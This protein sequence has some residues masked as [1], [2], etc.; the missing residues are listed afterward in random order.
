MMGNAGR[1]PIFW[2]TLAI[3]EQDFDGSGDLCIRCHSTGGWYAGRSEPTD[4]SGLAANDDDGVDCD[5]CH[6]MTNPDDSDPDL[7]G[8]MFS[9]YIANE[10][11]NPAEGYYGSGI[12][13]LWGGAEKLGP[14]GDAA[15][16]H[17]FAKSK[18]H[19]SV[20]FCGSC[21]DVSNPAVGDLA[22]NNG[23]Q[24]TA[25]PVVASGVP[26][27]AVDGKAAFN[28]PPY[29]YGVVERTFSEYKSGMVSQTPVSTYLSLPADLQDGSFKA[30]YE[31]AIVA[32]TG[33]DYEDGET[34]YF[35]CQT[36]HL[37]PVTGPGCNKKGAPVRPDLPL[38]D[39]TGGNYWI[40]DAIQW[41]DQQGTLRFGGG[42]TDLQNA[43]LDDGQV[44]AMKQ[45]SQAASLEVI[46]DTVKIVN[47]TGHK[48][49]TGYP[50]G[51]RMWLN[52]KWY[53]GNDILV[54]EDGAY[55]PIGINATDN[56]GVVREVKSLQNLHDPNTKIYEA[57]YGMT[58]EWAA[59][60]V[61][62]GYTTTMPLSFD[63]VTGDL[64]M[65]LG[66]L[67]GAE[68][69]TEHETFHFALNNTVI[70]DNRI[71]PYRMSY[72][73]ARK[74]NALPVPVSQYGDPGPGGEY[75]YWDEVNLSAPVG[76]VYA[77]INL[78]YQ[79]TSWE[80][81]QF[82]YLANNGQN[83]FLGQEGVNMLDA[84]LNTGMSEPYT[85]VSAIWGETPTPQITSIY[86]DSLIT[87][88]T[89]KKGSLTVESNTFKTQSTVAIIAHVVD[90]V[91]TPLSGAQ[92]FMEVLDSNRS[93]VTSLQEFTDANGEA[94]L[95]WKIPRRQAAGAY[96]A[97]V[98][99]ILKNGYE[100]SD[101][102]GITSVLF[103]IQ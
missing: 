18:F 2:A 95:R 5:A 46:G 12:L 22:H 69:E 55:G 7:Q 8:E 87:W 16:R 79:S 84:W 74:R 44:R 10:G 14:F 92:V 13:S 36:C 45:L 70:K 47:L 82:L 72:D 90:D 94:V 50:E 33:G 28:N 64:T 75:Q 31:S 99:T 35:S 3:A 17:K 11:Q 23:T 53:D 26:G 19:R 1:D 4:G 51:R 57:H 76:V 20:D 81:I 39:M 61:D 67:A 27:S 86:T 63:R 66:T 34:R 83:A 30:A 58:Q 48:L 32:G 96:S 68:A 80:Y 43:A 78:M 88:A 42:L 85:M 56:A 52:V 102:G 21:H 73:E 91:G 41:Q 97:E 6:K 49:I 101:Q 103:T 15:A 29:K 54:R 71:P 89:D 60:L 98:T 40:A 59:Q 38:H 25:D 65:D 93:L 37:R 9:P 62:L 77:E 100:Y 24:A